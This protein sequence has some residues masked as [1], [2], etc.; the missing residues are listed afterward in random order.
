MDIQ[1][2]QYTWTPPFGISLSLFIDNGVIYILDEN[3]VVSSISNTYPYTVTEYFNFGFDSDGTSQIQSCINV[4]FIPYVETVTYYIYR[5]CDDPNTS[6]Q[7]QNFVYQ[8]LPSISVNNF[9][10]F[11]DLNTNF[12]RLFANES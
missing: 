4:E 3:G 2:T 1:L 11:K 10:Y 12:W 5:S 7:E 8:T 6:G 9:V